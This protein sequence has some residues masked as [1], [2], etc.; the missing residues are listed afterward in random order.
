LN[1]SGNESFRSEK[2]KGVIELMQIII[3][4]LSINRSQNAETKLWI[5]VRRVQQVPR[6]RRV[7]FQGS[8]LDRW[9]M[10]SPKMLWVKGVLAVRMAYWN[11]DR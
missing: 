9:P 6:R 1:S 7:C 3:V 8:L 11:S 10:T 5:K 4:V 2:Q